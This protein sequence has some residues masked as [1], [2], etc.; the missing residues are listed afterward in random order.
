MRGFL[1]RTGCFGILVLALMAILD[2]V[3]TSGL[4]KTGHEAFRNWNEIMDTQKPLNADVL[5]MGSSRA[6]VQIS[7]LILD[8]VL[9]L[10]TY[11]IG[12]DG[13]GVDVHMTKYGIYREQNKAPRILVQVL[14][15]NTFQRRDTLVG[16]QQFMPYLSH[17][18]IM[19]LT[20][21]K[22]GFSILTYH[23]P[24]A[25]YFGDWNS[26]RIGILEAAGLRHY[27]F[28]RYYKGYEPRYQTWNEA[29]DDQIKLNRDPADRF[30]DS[31]LVRQF[32]SFVARRQEE[33]IKVVLVYPPHYKDM[34]IKIAEY[35]AIFDSLYSLS[36]Q[37]RAPFLNYAEDSMSLRRSNFYNS[38][39]MNA[40]ASAAFSQQLA[41]S[42]KN[43]VEKVP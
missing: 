12:Q 1:I 43:N 24:F 19:E 25:R 22:R 20:R 5:V 13:T 21:H 35:Q 33:G 23:V 26:I 36:R 38:T 15:L 32:K 11:V 41:L 39:H 29:E 34:K 9:R 10:N 40:V 6:R 17:P 8:S 28:P 27:V 2:R 7:P 31:S 30:F 37:C 4:R 3:V 18:G 14:D 16:H 42:L